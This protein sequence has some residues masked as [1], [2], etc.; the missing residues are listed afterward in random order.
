MP[1]DV[2]FNGQSSNPA[3]S[4][5]LMAANMDPRA[6]RPYIAEDGH[7][8]VDMFQRNGE[9]RAVRANAQATLTKEAWK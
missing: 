2:I 7:S 9:V 8:Y 3:I 6:L 4:E 1:I 5:K